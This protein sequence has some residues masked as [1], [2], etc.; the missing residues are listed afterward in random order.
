MAMDSPVAI[1][2]KILGIDAVYQD[3][4]SEGGLQRMILRDGSPAWDFVRR[5]RKSD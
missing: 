3:G 2:L 4:I 5:W 1:K